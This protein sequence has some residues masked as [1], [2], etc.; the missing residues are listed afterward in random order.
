MRRDIERFVERCHTCQLAKGKASNAGLYLP[1]P[2]PTQ[3]W[4]DVSMDFV[5]G[6]PRTQRGNDSIFVVV[7]RFSKMA[8]FV[9]CKKT[10]NA[11]NIE[12]LFFREIYK[13]YGLPLS[14]VSDRD[15]RFLGHFWRTLWKMLGTSLDMSSTFHPQTDGQT[16]VTNR[17]L[18][19][20]LRCLVGDNLKS[21]DDKLPRAEFAHNHAFNCSQGFSPFQVVFGIIPRAPLDMTTLLDRT[22]VHGE[23]FDF[24]TDLQDTHRLALD[25]LQV[26]T[27]RYKQD[28]DK[29]RRE[30]IFNLV[31]LFGLFS[32]RIAF[33]FENTTS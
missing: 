16:E 6:L 11:V 26:S 4:T 1:L 29:K 25:N 30:L 9:P 18:G 20:L 10:S 23:A 15:T 13:L 8:R 27:A 7:D 19:N 14:I 31:I 32:R 22:R 21:W 28:A 2:L 17:S 33:Q 3:P 12:V 5:L 24:V